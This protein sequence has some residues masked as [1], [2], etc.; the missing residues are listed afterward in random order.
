MNVNERV[1]AAATADP[2]LLATDI[3]DYL[4]LRGVPFRQAHE[5]VGKI[6]AHSLERSVPF[7]D[8]DLTTY[9]SFSD[10]F[11]QSVFK[12]FDVR[13]ALKARKATGA[14]SPAQVKRQI[15]RW[16]KLLP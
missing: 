8:I 7:Q 15:T 9:Q 4:V 5:I 13:A 14:P 1:T 11:D 16:R 2:F 12:V 10:A 3:A 6:T